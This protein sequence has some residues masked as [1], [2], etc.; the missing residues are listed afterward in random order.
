M[1]YV[2]GE[3]LKDKIKKGP[4][5]TADALDLVIQVA[6]GLAELRGGSSLTKSQTTLGTVAYM[7]PGALALKLLPVEQARLA[8]ARLSTRAPSR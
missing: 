4:L 8:T 3:T 5:D 7:S 1:E 6:A 2:G